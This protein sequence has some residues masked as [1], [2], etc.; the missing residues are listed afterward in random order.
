MRNF[1]GGFRAGVMSSSRVRV[2]WRQFFLRLELELGSI[3]SLVRYLRIAGS[4]RKTR[5]RAITRTVHHTHRVDVGTPSTIRYGIQ[6]RAHR[7]IPERVDGT[8]SKNSPSDVWASQQLSCA[9][10]Y[11]IAR[12]SY[13]QA[14]LTGYKIVERLPGSLR[15]RAAVV[16]SCITR[17][18]EKVERACA[19][20]STR[21]RGCRALMDSYGRKSRARLCAGLYA[22]ARPSCPHGL[23]WAKKSSAL[24]RGPLRDRAAVVPSWTRMGEQIER[25]C[26]RA[27]TRSRGRRALMHLHGRNSRA[28][29]ARA[30][31]R[32]RDP[33][34]VVSLW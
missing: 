16:P 3:L 26:A 8:G 7:A 15:A 2:N 34:T 33:R 30:Y 12:H 24:V 6:R 21:S 5:H 29:C 17:M 28:H 4:G 22:F 14:Y 11:V 1:P 18:G 25:A 20:A 23:A 13:R 32:S 19:R 10:P 31:A 27:Y 9:G